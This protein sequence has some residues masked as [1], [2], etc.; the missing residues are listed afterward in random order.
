M[1]PPPPRPSP[2]KTLILLYACVVRIRCTD[3]GDSSVNPHYRIII[4]WLIG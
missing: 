2:S 3:F 4:A 1:Q